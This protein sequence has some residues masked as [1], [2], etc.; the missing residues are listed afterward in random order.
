MPQSLLK[1]VLLYAGKDE[2][3]TRIRLT[4]IALPLV[5]FAIRHPA[6]CFLFTPR[7]Q[8]PPP[9]PLHFCTSASSPPE[10][11]SLPPRGQETETEKC[12]LSS[13][14]E[15]GIQLGKMNT[16]LCH[17]N[18]HIQHNYVKLRLRDQV[19]VQSGACSHQLFCNDMRATSDILCEFHLN[20]ESCWR[21]I[22]LKY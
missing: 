8:F 17:L 18:I 7:F 20:V 11:D 4:N 22:R 19:G 16:Q 12:L 9:P 3:E 5:I 21:Q 15:Q 2:L 6:E 10:M 13:F 14:A 1:C